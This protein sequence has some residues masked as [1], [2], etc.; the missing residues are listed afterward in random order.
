MEADLPAPAEYPPT[1]DTPRFADQAIS[2]LATA[3]AREGIVLDLGAMTV[4]IR[5]SLDNLVGPLRLVYGQY[6]QETPSCV[7]DVEV[8]LIH[9]AGIRGWLRPSLRFLADG[10]D[11][12]GAQPREMPLPQLEWG[13]NW[14]FAT[15]F[16]QHLL[17][18]AGSV[19]VNSHGLLLI[20]EPGSGK[21]TLT[22]AMTLDGARCLSD[23]F[24]V[25]RE[26]DCRLMPLTKPIALKNQSIG[27][28]KSWSEDAVLG[29]TYHKTHKGDVA[30]MAVPRQS[31]DARS[32][33]ATPR[34]IVFPK[35]H[36]DRPVAIE[37]L[38]RAEAFNLIAFNSF[39][40]TTTAESGFDLVDR[41]VRNCDCYRMEFGRLEDALFNLRRLTS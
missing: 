16:N 13:I 29:P 2:I 27:L 6:P 38:G 21:S 36:L 31:V 15:L 30:H 24:G 25:V 19:E 12:F 28:I 9:S 3:L 4:R 11:P 40:F 1:S 41:L 39:N 33:P 23:E 8:D 7:V 18:H 37:P 14:C 26:E 5:S 20:G 17:L 32:T 34:V 22:A 10:L 35:W